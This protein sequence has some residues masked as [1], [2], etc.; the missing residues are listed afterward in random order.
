VTATQPIARPPWVR[1][2]VRVASVLCLLSFTAFWIAQRV[3]HVS[4]IDVMVYRA[5][6]WAVRT[7]TDLYEL[8][9]TY[10]QLPNTYP[11]FA[12][13]V[14]TPLTLV[15]AAAMRTFTTLMNLGLLVVFVQL[16]LR[17]LG[18]PLTLPF[19]AAVPA[20]AAMAVWSEPVWTTVRY[21][22]V[23]LLLAVLV[24]WDLTR[25]ADHRWAGVG[26]G[27][28]AGMKLTPALFAVFLAMAGLALAWRRVR[29]GARAW[30]PL[31]RRAL[32]SVAAFAGTASVT[33][34]VLPR[35]SWTYWTE[36]LFATDRPGRVEDVANQSLRGVL[37]RALHSAESTDWW[38]P[39]AAVVGCAG[40]AVAVAAL[41]A[42]ERGLP[43]ANAWA[44]V[45]C[46]VTGLII[47]PISWS[48]HWVWAVPMVLLLTVEARHR[49]SAPWRIGAVLAGLVFC[50]YALW[51]VPHGDT[52]PELHL[53]LGQTAL[54][55]AYPLTGAVFLAVAAAVSLRAL[56]TGW[57]GSAEVREVNR[58]VAD[59]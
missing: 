1:H 2:P 29:Q 7:G 16:S 35:D 6:G 41:L 49:R 34:V 55:A 15:T 51:L 9:A 25:R 33:A 43:H 20:I 19:T 8:R 22:Q 11:P 37:A 46:G 42:G 10:A 56:R 44:A 21:G 24:L 57:P 5:E 23:N 31:L 13:L 50:S 40:L 17:L 14:F 58:V 4:M 53:S 47:S 39:A 54:S 36:V 28:A 52:R 45:S 48:H 38:L 30:N 59:N 26:I 32:V 18:R 12:A 27:V 3:A